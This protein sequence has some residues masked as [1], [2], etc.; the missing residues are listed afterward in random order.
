MSSGRSQPGDTGHHHSVKP[1][2]VPGCFA[3]GLPASQAAVIAAT[4]RPLAASALAATFG[5][6]GLEDHPVLGRDRDGGPRH[7]GR[8]PDVHG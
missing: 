6:P 2:L 7:P 5:T 4:Q 3:N 1:S 8:E